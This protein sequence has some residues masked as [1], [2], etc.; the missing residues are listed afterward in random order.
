MFMPSHV[1]QEMQ[2]QLSALHITRHARGHHKVDKVPDGAS[3]KHSRP[4]EETL[5]FIGTVDI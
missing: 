4:K 3:A 1:R 2:R 5:D